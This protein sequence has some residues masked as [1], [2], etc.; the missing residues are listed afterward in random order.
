MYFLLS[1]K[2]KKEAMMTEELERI[3]GTEGL[4]RDLTEMVGRML[5]D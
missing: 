2:K 4:S 5:A 1:L 3:A